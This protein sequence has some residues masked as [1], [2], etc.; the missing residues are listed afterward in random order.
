MSGVKLHAVELRRIRMSL[1]APFETSFGRVT[2]Q[3]T[4]LVEAVG[5]GV[6]G[7]GEVPASAQ[8][9]YSSETVVTAAVDACCN[10]A[11]DCPKA[12]QRASR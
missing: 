4:I 5:D 6:S 1:V 2:Q 9:H 12:A 8:P 3:E 7:W 11:M 10:R